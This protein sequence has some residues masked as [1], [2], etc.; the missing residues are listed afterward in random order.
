[1]TQ[2]RLIGRAAVLMSAAGAEHL[3]ERKDAALLALLAL[4]GPVPRSRVAGLLWPQAS[5]VAA[6]GNLRQRLFRLRAATGRALVQPGATL[7]LLD[8]VT[9]DIAALHQRLLD[10]PNAGQGDLLAGL[11]YSDHDEL[12]HWV[13][14]ARDRWRAT[15]LGLLAQLASDHESR[16]EIAAALALAQR[17]LIDEP[18]LEHAHRRVMRLHY[19]RGDRAAALAAYERCR[20]AL[21]EQLGLRPSPETVELA[22]VVEASAAHAPAAPALRPVTTLRPPCL[23]GREAEWQRAG[24]LLAQGGCVR[25]MGEAGIGKTRFM[26]ERAAA[27]AGE[28]ALECGARAGDARLPYALA[29]RLA[30]RLFERWHLPPPGWARAELAR[31]APLPGDAAPG[32]LAPGRLAQAL[33]AALDAARTA[34]L[35]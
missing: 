8:D 2:L 7:R 17:L 14:Q 6:R 27:S 21:G 28:E 35:A 31:I 32:P 23:V 19:L 11:D 1:M 22:R 34:G 10:D 18:L 26:A 9:L 16:R 5:A 15:R 24:A 33:A 20:S 12:E 13:A 3:L 25:V 4:D 30:H 29:A